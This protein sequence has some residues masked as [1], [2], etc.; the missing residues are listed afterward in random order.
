VGRISIITIGLIL[1]YT[2]LYYDAFEG[3]VLL[4]DTVQR[5]V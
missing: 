3:D 5:I 2:A 4:E 1:A